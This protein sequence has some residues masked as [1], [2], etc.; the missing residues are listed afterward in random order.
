MAYQESPVYEDP[1]STR[2]FGMQTW[3][4]QRVAEYYYLTNDPLAKE[5]LDKW[6]AWV[7]AN[8]QL[9]GD[10]SFAIPGDLG[11]SG[12][13]DVWNPAAPGPNSN[14]HVTIANYNQD[15]GIVASLARTLL[16]YSAGT[17]QWAAQNTAAKDVARALIDRLWTN[18]RDSLG[19]S[20]GENRGDYTRFFEQT[21]YAPPGWIGHMPNGDTVTNGATFLGIRSKYLQDP[22]FPALTN[23]YSAWVAGGRVGD[24]QSPTYH[25]HRFWAQ[26]EV[27]LANATYDL[28]FPGE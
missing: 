8:V 28:L 16:Y 26:V 2:W 1:P 6:V 4:M 9:P 11:W 20:V 21:V 15:L 7:L 12:Q 5:V 22:G 10:G 19:V 3:S 24:F 25:Y 17:K 14:L 18:C 27:A 13:P 23:A